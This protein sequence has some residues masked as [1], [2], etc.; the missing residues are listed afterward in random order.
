MKLQ[1][2]DA[3]LLMGSSRHR[4]YVMSRTLP[5]G[6]KIYPHNEDP[7]SRR[8]NMPKKERLIPK[9]TGS[10]VGPDR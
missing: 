2:R 1:N 4:S 3:D 7:P 10:W 5:R 9:H 8:E 6:G